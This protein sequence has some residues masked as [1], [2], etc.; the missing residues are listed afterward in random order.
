MSIPPN[1][2]EMSRNIQIPVVASFSPS[3][4]VDPELALSDAYY[5]ESIDMSIPVATG[6]NSTELILL[7]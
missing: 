2:L 7:K 3:W 6:L 5:V 1:I 4:L